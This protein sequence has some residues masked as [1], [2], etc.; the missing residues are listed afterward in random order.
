MKTTNR[1]FFS[2]E[3]DDN[4]ASARTI[5]GDLVVLAEGSLDSNNAM[6]HAGQTT[7]AHGSHS[8]HSSNHSSH[9]S[10]G[11]GGGGR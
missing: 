11:S 8:S 3:L 5:G 1:E 4:Y 9:A 2:S 6:K 10:H 7:L